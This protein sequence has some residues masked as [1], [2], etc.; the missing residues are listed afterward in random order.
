M[1]AD[2]RLPQRKAQLRK[3]KDRAVY[4]LMA[5]ASEAAAYRAAQKARDPADRPWNWESFG[6]RRH[7]A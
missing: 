3:I 2:R 5:E 6:K 1:T 4:R 7:N